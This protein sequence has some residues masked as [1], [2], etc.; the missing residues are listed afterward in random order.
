MESQTNYR[1]EVTNLAVIFWEPP[2][3]SQNLYCRKIYI[4]EI[5]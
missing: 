1:V 4:L 5:G 3:H 2:L